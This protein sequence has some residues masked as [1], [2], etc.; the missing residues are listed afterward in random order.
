M[1][2][3]YFSTNHKFLLRFYKLLLIQVYHFDDN[4]F[5]FLWK[6]NDKNNIKYFN[7]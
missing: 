2:K 1:Y 3:I 7:L 5:N 4:S 6:P